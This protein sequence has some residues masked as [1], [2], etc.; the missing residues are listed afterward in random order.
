M[1]SKARLAELKIILKEEYKLN[2]TDEEVS[3][4]GNNLLDYFRAM[5]EVYTRNYDD[6][7]KLVKQKALEK[8]RLKD[9]ERRKNNIIIDKKNKKDYNE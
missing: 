2:L 8:R 4:I 3:V 9:R 6:V 5:Y 1:V 7:H